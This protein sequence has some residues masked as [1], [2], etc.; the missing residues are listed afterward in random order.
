MFISFDF[1]EFF[2]QIL[3]LLLCVPFRQTRENKSET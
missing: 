2:V 1:N 3:F